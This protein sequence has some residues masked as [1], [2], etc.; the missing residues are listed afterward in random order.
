MPI[1]ALIAGAAG[2]AGGLIGKSGQEAANAKNIAMAR[3]QMAFQERM[4]STAYQRS[5][6]DLDAAGLNRILA[7]GSPASTPAGQTAKVLNTKT[8]L[9]QGVTNAVSTAV[10]LRKTEAEI[11][12]IDAQTSL[13]NTRGLIAEHGEEVASVAAD[14]ARTVRSL[15]GN[16][17]PEQISAIIKS[18][19]ATASGQLTNILERGGS[20]AATIGRALESAKSAISMFVNDNILDERIVHPKILD[21]E[22]QRD[23]YKRETKGKDISFLQ[24]QFKRNKRF[25]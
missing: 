16:K 23:K 20:T 17:T 7:L 25:R 21:K 19:I 13:T 24:W 11:K 6:K 3:E 15:I 10:S 5:A 18:T 4:S 1:G 8:L 12:N 2:I 14:I 22:T 9:A